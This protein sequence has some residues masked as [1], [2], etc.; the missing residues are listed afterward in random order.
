[1]ACRLAKL[2]PRQHR[3]LVL[4]LPA[5][6]ALVEAANFGDDAR[7]REIE[8]TR[9]AQRPRDERDAA[10]GPHQRKPAPGPRRRKP[11]PSAT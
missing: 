10:P 2:P 7:R 8:R 3:A 11:A 1:M 5:I 6:E 9:D 4:A